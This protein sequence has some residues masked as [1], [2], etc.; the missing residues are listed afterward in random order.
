[1]DD[2]FVKEGVGWRLGWH[3]QAADYQG[4][5]GGS[6]WAVELTAM[7][8]QE[9]CRLAQRLADQIQTLAQ[10]L[11]DEER[12]TCEVESDLLWLEAEGRPEAFALRFIVQSGRR[13]EGGWAAEATGELLQAIAQLTLF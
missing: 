7:E 2:R 13:C 6:S 8:F 5:L 11:M 3:G 1:M 9:F 10:E 4:L 12:L